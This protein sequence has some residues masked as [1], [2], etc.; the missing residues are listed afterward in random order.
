MCAKE[1]P[2]YVTRKEL[3]QAPGFDEAFPEAKNRV[4]QMKIRVIQI[5][6]QVTQALFE[7]Y[8]ALALNVPY[9]DFSTH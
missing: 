9:N 6:D 7:I 2:A 3:E 8:A 1:I 5:D 4:A